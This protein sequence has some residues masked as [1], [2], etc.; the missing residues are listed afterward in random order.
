[1]IAVLLSTL[2][3]AG[4]PTS[5]CLQE[6]ATIIE[7]RVH[8][9]YETP[10]SEILR[11]A[12]VPVGAEATDDVLDSIRRRLMGSGRFAS[13]RILRRYRTLDARGGVVLIIFVKEGS[14]ASELPD[15]LMFWPKFTGG[16]GYGFSAGGQAALIDYF[17]Y[18]ER[19]SAYAT[20][21]GVKQVCLEAEVGLSEFTF[22]KVYG[23][24]NLSRRFHPTY[25]KV[26]DRLDA[27][28]GAT[29]QRGWAQ[30]GVEA[31]LAD[32][33]YEGLEG[34][35]FYFRAD[36]TVD[37]RAES[38]IPGN[39][40]RLYAS[41]ERRW[42]GAGAIDGAALAAWSGAGD[43]SVDIYELDVRLYKRLFGHTALCAQLFYITSGGP[44]PTYMKPFNGRETSVRGHETGLWIGDRMAVGKIEYRVP[45]HSLAKF[46]R[47]GIHFFA[48][49]GTALDYGQGFDAAE[50]RYGVGCGVFASI[51]GFGARLD[52][53]HNLEGSFRVHFGSGFSF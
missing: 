21:G 37:S 2:L 29:Y 36:A 34:S 41:W 43:Y 18:G 50:W 46:Y 1:M 9:N 22:S 6:D 19:L 28:A 40:V 35:Y 26:M 4:A 45:L 38:T 52:L 42:V 15:K 32:I 30:L 13:V 25:E 7:V 33:D 39:D 47:Y 51:A 24:V 3:F 14:S 10:D 53:A 20:Y 16:E 48:D 31:G 49:A 5:L 23:G 27:W 8:G 12:D 44:L 17:G 11:L